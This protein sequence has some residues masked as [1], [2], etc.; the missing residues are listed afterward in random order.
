MLQF[1]L[2][3][4]SLGETD[5][6]TFITSPLAESWYDLYVVSHTLMNSALKYVTGVADDAA[7]LSYSAL[8]SLALI[9]S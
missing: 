2:S 8:E 1:S 9:R 5:M 7:I 3:A 6:Q 4:G